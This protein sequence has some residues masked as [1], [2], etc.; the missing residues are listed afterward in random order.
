MTSVTAIIRQSWI[1]LTGDSYLPRQRERPF[2]GISGG[3]G[4]LRLRNSALQF[5]AEG[6]PDF[7]GVLKDTARQRKVD[8]FA[9]LPQPAKYHLR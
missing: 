8:F 5:S 1:H 3:E 2:S 4:N 7:D 6:S 9:G